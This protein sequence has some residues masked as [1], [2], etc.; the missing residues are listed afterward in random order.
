MVSRVHIC[1]PTPETA[2]IKHIQFTVYQLYFNQAV[3]EK[4]EGTMIREGRLG[5]WRERLKAVSSS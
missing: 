1:A 4:K 2:F 5:L 3:K